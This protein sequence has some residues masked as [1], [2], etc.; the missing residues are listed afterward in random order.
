[1][2]REW[3]E[4]EM[5]SVVTFEW[6]RELP[7]DEVPLF[8]VVGDRDPRAFEPLQDFKVY[9]IYCYYSNNEDKNTCGW[10][11]KVFNM[12]GRKLIKLNI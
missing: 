1:M 12:P 7:K 5:G 11:N 8:L 6:A 4:F 3:K 10:I 2:L 9:Q